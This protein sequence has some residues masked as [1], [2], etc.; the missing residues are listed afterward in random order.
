MTPPAPAEALEVE[1]GV[2]D[3]VERDDAVPD[4]L[5]HA[6]DLAIAPLVQ[7][8]RDVAGVALE[9]L[10]MVGLRQP[11]LQLDAALERIHLGGGDRLG[12]RDDVELDRPVARVHQPVRQLAVGRQ[13][14]RA[15]R[16]AVEAADGEQAFSLDSRCDVEDG[17]AAPVVR[18]RRDRVGGLVEEHV[19]ETPSPIGRP[20]TSTRSDGETWTPIS[21]TTSPFRVT[22]PSAISPSAARREA[23]PARAR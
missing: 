18:C 7:L 5:E 4:R 8:E 21:V 17:A 12:D 10:G 16:G 19:D 13:Q 6:A 1:A 9:A 23:T 2:A 14:E 22:W 3:A 11:V 20:S 15:G